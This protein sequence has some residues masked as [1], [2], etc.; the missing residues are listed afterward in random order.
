MKLSK[1]ALISMG[2]A[3]TSRALRKYFHK[4][5]HI[6]HKD[7]S[8]RQVI[9]AN[10]SE[11]E[12]GEWAYYT[13]AAFDF[14]V[15]KDDA[16]QSYELVIEYDGIQH[17]NPDQVRKDVLK[18]RL[19]V[20]AGLPILGIGVEDIKIRGD[21]TILEYMLDLYFGEKALEGLKEEGRIDAD[22]DYFILTRFPET[23]RIIS[24]LKKKGIVSAFLIHL[25]DNRYG[26]SE[27]EKF[28][29][30]RIGEKALKSSSDKSSTLISWKADVRVDIIKGW[31]VE[32]PVI[33][34]ERQV[35]LKE[36]NPEYNVPGI[37]RWFLALQ[38]AH[39]MCFDEVE[40]KVEKLFRSK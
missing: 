17:E 4:K 6:I 3:A 28:Y 34:V 9:D 29:W 5:P 2:E 23:E 36:C 27:A 33:T 31:K 7:V 37:H 16:A 24:R 12:P 19:C 20:Q 14:V 1:G 38:L 18:N 10:R 32:E 26:K 30:Y 22:E 40:R 13:K 8:V 21:L 39:F 15:C 11:L 35:T 25:I